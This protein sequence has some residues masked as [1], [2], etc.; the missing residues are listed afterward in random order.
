[1]TTATN[2]GA[3]SDSTKCYE[4]RR[5]FIDKDEY[6]RTGK[7]NKLI[8]DTRKL[9]DIL[10]SEKVRWSLDTARLKLAK[11]QEYCLLFTRFG[12]C[13]KENVKCPYIHDP[14]K[15]A[16]CT[17][18]LKGMCLGLNCKLTQKVIPERMQDC[19]YFL[20]GCEEK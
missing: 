5:L 12:K 15:I 13:N 3:G 9:K 16:V 8:R 18:F 17:K 7:G 11:K 6:I 1:M 2:I 19:S 20:Q 14:N 10:G 4:P